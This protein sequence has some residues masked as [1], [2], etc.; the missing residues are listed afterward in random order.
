[1]LPLIITM[2]VTL[3]DQW[4]KLWV[5][6]SF[7]LG[8]S[9]PVIEGFF[10]F[11]Y[12]R[13]PGAAWGMF[14]NHNIALTFLSII[15]LAVLAIFRRSFLSDTLDHRIALGLMAGG[16]IGNL[17]DRIKYGY[18]VDFLDV[19]L[20]FY[21]WPVFNIADAAICVGVGIYVVSSLWANAHPLH[22]QRNKLDVSDV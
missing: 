21:H 22:A 2:L 20:G 13:N 5:I 16:I 9:R 14:G 3:L 17:I 18:V 15:M 8:E 10:H 19:H 6:G 7:G 12:V 1:M 4:T 11:T